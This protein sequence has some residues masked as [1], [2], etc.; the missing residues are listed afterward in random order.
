MGIGLDKLRPSVSLFHGIAPGKRVQPLGQ[1]DLPVCFGTPSNFRKV[2]LTFEVV[3]FRG[4]YH[5]I[6]GRPCYARFMAVPNYTYLKTKMLGPKG[7]ITVGPSFDHAYE[8]DVECVERA[9]AQAEDEALAAS[10]DKMVS[11]VMDSTHRHAGSFEPAEGIKKVPLDP[12]HPHDRALQNV[13]AYVDDVIVKSRKA[14]DL[15]N[16]LR[17][18]FDCLRAKGK[19]EAIK[20]MG[21]IRDLKGVQ[22]VMGY[23]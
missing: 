23:L 22:R 3:G 14:D 13:E 17:I 18:A 19:V 12:S 2:V 8:C 10:L 9:E 20:W 15:V 16:D 21:P 11:E 4:A 5:A 6:L 1:I 7:I